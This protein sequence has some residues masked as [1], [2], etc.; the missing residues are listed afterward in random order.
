[1][2]FVTKNSA[3]ASWAV[4]DNHTNTW[5]RGYGRWTKAQAEQWAEYLNSTGG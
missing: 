2:R 3:P 5:A 4:W 1:M